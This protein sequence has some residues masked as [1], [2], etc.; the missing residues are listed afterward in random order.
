M[1]Q[2]RT[3]LVFLS[4][5]NRRRTNI[6]HRRLPQHITNLSNIASVFKRQKKEK[7][8]RIT[9]VLVNCITHG[10]HYAGLE[11]ILTLSEVKFHR[12]ALAS[13]CCAVCK[14]RNFV[15]WRTLKLCFFLFLVNYFKVWLKVRNTSF[16]L[17]YMDP[18]DEITKEIKELVLNQVW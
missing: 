1:N 4:H 7:K 18:K 3:S 9:L 17:S 10:Y 6:K 11:C 12:S 14:S 16:R 5:I 2:V 8:E 15:S 13:H